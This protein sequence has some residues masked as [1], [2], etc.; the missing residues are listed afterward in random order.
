MEKSSYVKCKKCGFEN[1]VGT[2]KC[3]KCN[4]SFENDKKSCPR[5]AKRNNIFAESCINCG[6]NFN[7]RKRS[8]WFDLLISFF[9]VILFSLLVILHFNDVVEKISLAMKII[10]GV[11]IFFIIIGT[12]TYGSKDIVPLVDGAVVDNNRKFKLT[13]LIS[14]L[15]ILIGLLIVLGILAFIIYKRFF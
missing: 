2:K 9:I 13:K 11:A 10:A 3:I 15:I 1:V 5:C 6:Y 12:F 8:V 14:L 4:T 7:K